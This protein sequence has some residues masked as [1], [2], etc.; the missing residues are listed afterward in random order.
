ML[1]FKASSSYFNTLIGFRYCY[2]LFQE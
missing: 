1:T 2:E